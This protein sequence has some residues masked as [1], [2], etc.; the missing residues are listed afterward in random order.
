MLGP[1]WIT[2]SMAAMLIGM[3][4]LYSALFNIPRSEF[5]PHLTLGIIFWTFIS[6]TLSDGCSVFINAARYLKQGDFSATLFAWRSITKNSLQLAHH[7]VLFIPVSMLC[8]TALSWNIIYLIPG[9]VA[10]LINLH[11]LTI[12]LGIV[13]AR[14]RD[15]VQ[16]VTS[17]MQLLMF[18][19]PVF[20]IPSPSTSAI[21][22]I[23]YNPFSHLLDVLR[24]P[25]LGQA[26]LPFTWIFI[27]GF[28]GAN[29]VLAA[30]LFGAKR[31]RL[32]YWI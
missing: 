12:S 19:T 5:F 8:G 1:L 21:A 22:T 27:A 9:F 15:V 18:L 24:G 31:H 7:L 26:P 29:L 23:R 10:V 17:A 6:T 25:L 2:V 4:P 14:F 3:G 32:T 20:W 28:T 30:L 13:C 16:M 11:L